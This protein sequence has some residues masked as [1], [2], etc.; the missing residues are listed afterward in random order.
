MSVRPCLDLL[1]LSWV[2]SNTGPPRLASRHESR[3]AA[4]RPAALVRR[5]G[6]GSRVRDLCVHPSRPA[7]PGIG[8]RAASGSSC[9][10]ARGHGLVS[11]RRVGRPVHLRVEARRWGRGPV[12]RAVHRAAVGCAYAKTPSQPFQQVRTLLTSVLHGPVHGEVAAGQVGDGPSS[13]V[14]LMNSTCDKP[15]APSM[16]CWRDCRRGDLGSIH[17]R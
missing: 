17:D 1:V 10:G 16:A 5:D 12:P 11:F 13:W 8:R 3:S 4:D 15:A 7:D 6:S 9:H 2:P 14:R